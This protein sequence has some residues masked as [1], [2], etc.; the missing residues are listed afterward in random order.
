LSR[1]RAFA[2]SLGQCFVK[3]LVLGKQL[4]PEKV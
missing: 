2:Q 4:W 3:G 1:L